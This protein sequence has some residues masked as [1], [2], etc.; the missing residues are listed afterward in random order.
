MWR[1][2]LIQ[3]PIILR[4]NA[5]SLTAA[6]SD[7]LR[8]WQCEILEHPPYSPNMSPCDYNLF[9]KVKEPLRGT[10]YKTRDELIRSIRRSIRKINKDGRVGGVRCPRNIW[11]KVINNGATISKVL[12]CCTLQARSQPYESGRAAYYP[13]GASKF[14]SF[15]SKL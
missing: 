6:V 10:G 3:N 4:D 8:R 12:K 5:R 15:T 1:Y 2:L 11:H 9:V 13:G 7:L 14:H